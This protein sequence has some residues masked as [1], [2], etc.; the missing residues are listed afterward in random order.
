MKKPHTAKYEVNRH[1]CDLYLSFAI[2][3]RNRFPLNPIGLALISKDV[4]T[5]ARRIIFYILGLK[6]TKLFAVQTKQYPELL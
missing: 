3:R 1:I 4:V 6:T 5:Q 2:G